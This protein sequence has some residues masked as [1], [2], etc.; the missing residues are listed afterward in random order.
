MLDL[1]PFINLVLNM[2]MI[3]LLLRFE[4]RMTRVETLVSVLKPR[5]EIER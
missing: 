1:T 2:A 5:K 3:A 4:G